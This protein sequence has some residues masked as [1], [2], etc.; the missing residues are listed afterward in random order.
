M[1]I[2]IIKDYNK[3]SW[4]LDKMIKKKINKIKNK[5]KIFNY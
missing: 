4:L 2:K 3:F 1:N 5:I